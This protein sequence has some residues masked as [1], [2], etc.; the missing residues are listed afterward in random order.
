MPSMSQ[1]ILEGVNRRA[2]HLRLLTDP[3]RPGT[4]PCAFF[5]DITEGLRSSAMLRD[6]L[7]DA[8]RLQWKE[9]FDNEV[10]D[11]DLT[12]KMVL[13]ACEVAL[14][15]FEAINKRALAQQEEAIRQDIAPQFG[16]AMES[17]RQATTDVTVLR[18]DFKSRW[19]WVDQD[20][21]DRSVAAERQGVRRLSVR[22]VHDELRRRVR[23]GGQG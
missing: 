23:P 9:A 8:I 2:D 17:F 7:V 21:F 18:R 3:D 12:G 11:Y 5:L 14:Q 4:K 22:E 16:E 19:P 1:N 10:E 6:Y 15:V 20:K 13:L